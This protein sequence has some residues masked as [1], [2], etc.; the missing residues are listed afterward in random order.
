MSGERCNLVHC[1]VRG[2]HE[3][4]RNYVGQ[5]WRIGNSAFHPAGLRSVGALFGKDTPNGKTCYD[6]A[7]YLEAVQRVLDV[8]P[9]EMPCG[10]ELM[11][12]DAAFNLGVDHAMNK[13][14]E[15]LGQEPQ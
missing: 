4:H 14:R 11:P 7:A 15:A 13:I 10:A 6:G 5:E 2:E 12:G 8:E 1:V 3:V 9:V